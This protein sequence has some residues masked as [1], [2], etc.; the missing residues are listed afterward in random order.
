MHMT[1]HIWARLWHHQRYLKPYKGKKDIIT[2]FCI[3][4]GVDIAILKPNVANW[5]SIS[6][7][8]DKPTNQPTNSAL[9]VLRVEWVAQA[10][11]LQVSTRL[12]ALTLKYLDIH[13]ILNNKSSTQ[14]D[15]ISKDS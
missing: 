12:E 8:N 1:Q 15:I 11:Q 3:I 14:Q 6:I 7:P 4:F 13:Y 10:V 2:A 5:S 9:Q